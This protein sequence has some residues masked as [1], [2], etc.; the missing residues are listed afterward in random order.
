[1]ASKRNA[2]AQIRIVGRAKKSEVSKRILATKSIALK[3]SPVRMK[4]LLSKSRPAVKR[5]I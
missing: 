5:V 2:G 1:L 4:A 3:G